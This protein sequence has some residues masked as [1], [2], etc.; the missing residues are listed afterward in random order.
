VSGIAAVDLMYAARG[1][2]HL[3]RGLETS[4]ADLVAHMVDAELD[5]IDA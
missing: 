3:R 4:F 2:D 1:P 5:L